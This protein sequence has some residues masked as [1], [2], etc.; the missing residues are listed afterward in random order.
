MKTEILINTKTK[1][2]VT[3]IIEALM[4]SKGIDHFTII[5][6]HIVKSQHQWVTKIMEI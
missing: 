2:K 5:I 4:N 3:I 6:R 1:T